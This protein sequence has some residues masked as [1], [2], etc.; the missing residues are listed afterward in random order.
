MSHD[1]AARGPRDPREHR[2]PHEAP[3][4]DDQVASLLSAAQF[5]V[6]A[7]I[8]GVVATLMYNAGMSSSKG[9]GEGGATRPAG[10]GAAKVDVQLLLLPTE[11]LVVKGK[12]VFTVNCASCHGMTG[13]G[14]GPAAA[15]LNPKPRNFT[16]GYWRYGGGVARIVQTITGGSP[17][18]AMAA[19]TSI[20]LQDRFAIAHFI[21]SLSPKPEPDKPEDLAWLDQFGGAK[22]GGEAAAPASGGAAPAGPTIPVEKALVLLAE[23]SPPI[24]TPG[25]GTDQSGEGAATYASR[26]ASCHGLAGEGGVRVRALGSAPYVY[27]ATRSLGAP[28]S[29]WPTNF[30]RFEEIVLRGIEGF[31]MPGNGDLTQSQL[32]ALYL[33]TQNL[34]A[35]QDAAGRA[36]S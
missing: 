20:P 9:H 23:A 26:C 11:E 31:V 29:D 28:S 30:A 10:T 22:A 5:V 8:L 35:M 4:G 3:P 24:G 13:K 17:G 2:D 32:R 14:D 12:S 36:R 19:F 25:D 7:V 34:R 21:R 6:T 15:A 18:T 1:P 16:E 33:H 27:L